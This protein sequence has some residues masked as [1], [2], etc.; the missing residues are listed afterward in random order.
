MNAKFVCD[1]YVVLQRHVGHVPDNEDR[2]KIF[3]DFYIVDDRIFTFS[4][5]ESNDYV[6]VYLTKI[7]EY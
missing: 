3:D 4:K 7:S 5:K 2:I 1:G 6:T